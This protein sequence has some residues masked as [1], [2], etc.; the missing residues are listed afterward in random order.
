MAWAQGG[1]CTD[2]SFLEKLGKLRWLND[3]DLNTFNSNLES[4]LYWTLLPSLLFLP[5]VAARYRH[6]LTKPLSHS[7]PI[8]LPTRP[9]KSAALSSNKEFIVLLRRRLLTYHSCRT[10]MYSKDPV[11]WTW[12]FSIEKEKRRPII[13]PLIQLSGLQT[14]HFSLGWKKIA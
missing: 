7:F 1:A 14:Q 8:L 3:H 12:F 10:Q 2:H 13:P 11:F 4:L 5:H 6:F 9:E